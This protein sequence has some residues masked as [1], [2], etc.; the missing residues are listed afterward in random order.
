MDGV[1]KR[2]GTYGVAAS[3]ASTAAPSFASD[4]SRAAAM[5]RTVAHVGFERSSSIAASELDVRPAR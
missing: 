5:A 2:L 4:T 3:S 1:L